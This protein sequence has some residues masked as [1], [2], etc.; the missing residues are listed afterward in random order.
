M[1]ARLNE[2]IHLLP[3]QV[4]DIGIYKF[5]DTKANDYSTQTVR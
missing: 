2:A 4:G 3:Q 1:H 5:I